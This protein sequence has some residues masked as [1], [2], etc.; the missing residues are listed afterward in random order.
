MFLSQITSRKYS[1]EELSVVRSVHP[2]TL[3]K[4]LKFN[5]NLDYLLDDAF[6]WDSTPQKHDYWSNLNQARNK[7][8]PLPAEAREFLKALLKYHEK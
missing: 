6:I 5:K 2:D 1:D 7:Y 8:L 3:K 4:L